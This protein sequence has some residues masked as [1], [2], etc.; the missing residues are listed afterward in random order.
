M[1]TSCPEYEKKISSKALACPNRGHPGSFAEA[2]EE[3][4]P[5][6]ARP[7]EY[8]GARASQTPMP[9]PSAA[10]ESSRKSL[11]RI[12]AIVLAGG[13]ILEAFAG[14]EKLAPPPSEQ[15][16][17]A[18]LDKGVALGQQD[19]PDVVIAALDEV[20]RRSGQEASPG[21]RER[22]AMALNNK[23]VTLGQQG[24]PDAAI[25]VYDEIDRRFGQDDSPGVREQVAR[26]LY[27]K[28]WTLGQQGK[29][30][31]KIAV[32]DE[33]V[34]R[35]G[36][37]DSPGVREQ[38]AEAQ[39]AKK[40]L[41]ASRAREARKYFEQGEAAEKRKQWTEA[42]ALYTQAIEADPKFADAYANRSSVYFYELDDDES[43][44]RDA[45]AA[46]DLG[47]NCIMKLLFEAIEA[48]ENNPNI[49][50]E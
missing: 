47:N 20:D 11:K 45:K 30:D 46:C 14:Y 6:A 39:A 5:G 24:K 12:V 28:G 42:V 36:K 10:R 48:A 16:A 25:G 33:V 4:A 2:G 9:G 32:Y 13:V 1:L 23:G 27:N 40:P 3:K 21:A 41:I 37:D 7:E 15:A 50:K 38:V 43:A 29:T 44:K 19:K 26:A 34:R 18:L 31:A 49:S 8:P 17:T 22:V 35:F